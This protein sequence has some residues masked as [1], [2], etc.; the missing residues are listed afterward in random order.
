MKK[1][2]LCLVLALAMLLS[3]VAC[4]GNNNTPSNDNQEPAPTT[5]DNNTPEPAPTDDGPAE[6]QPVTFDY[7][8]LYE[9]AYGS[10]YEALTAA[11]AAPDNDSRLALMAAAE[12]QL[13][14]NGALMPNNSRGGNYAIGRIVPY[15]VPSVKWGSDSDR[16]ETV[17]AITDG[18]ISAEERAEMREK[19]N[20]LKGTGTYM[21]WVKNYITVE[22]GHTLT[23]A[24][25]TTY[26][27]DPS[28]WD[29]LATFDA[30]NSEQASMTVDGLLKYD[31]E[32]LQQPALA[33]S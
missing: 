19:W 28:T 6:F 20:E 5:D 2:F 18:F 12:A 16:E 1:K 21:E 25:G 10:F 27:T 14:T 9:G 17:L 23:D 24:Y 7:D 8:T 32:T 33:T 22:R 3:L 11:K 26:S 15:T 31:V 13:L 30:T 29:V 4:G